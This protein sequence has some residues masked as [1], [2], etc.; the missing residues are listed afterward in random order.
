MAFLAQ[1]FYLL[2]LVAAAALLIIGYRARLR[3]L[4]LAAVVIAPTAF[5]LAKIGALMIS[6]PRPFIQSGV[7]PLIAGSQDNGFPSD[8][9]LL[10][11]AVAA[12]VTVA[13]RRLGLLFWALAAVVGMARVYARVHHPVDVL[14]SLL[15]AALALAIYA[16]LRRL[17]VARGVA[18]TAP[19]SNI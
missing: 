16:A 6:S 1:D 14:G 15:F 17:W 10:L 7:A 18:R 9:T 13:N 11:G 19:V 8:H 12:V 4:A 2:V 5:V 3:E